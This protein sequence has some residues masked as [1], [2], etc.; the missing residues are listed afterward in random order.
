MTPRA[1][2]PTSRLRKAEARALPRSW[3]VRR[4]RIRVR[5]RQ[6]LPQQPPPALHPHTMRLPNSHFSP[7]SKA[8]RLLWPRRR[9]RPLIRRLRKRIRLPPLHRLQDQAF[10]RKPVF[11]LR[12]LFPP[13]RPSQRLQHRLPLCWP[14][15]LMLT[16]QASQSRPPHIQE[17]LMTG[18][19]LPPQ[20]H[21]R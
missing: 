15:P 4:P 10:R 21:P 5:I 13:Q 14:R 18:R 17:K 16:R 2:L 9:P 6:R 7:N 20:A 8:V 3:P 19:S 11:G 1:S 12:A